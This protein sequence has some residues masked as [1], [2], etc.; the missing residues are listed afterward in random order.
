MAD[1]QT[2]SPAGIDIGATLGGAMPAGLQDNLTSLR[3]EQSAE[4]TKTVDSI[5]KNLDRDTANTQRWYNAQEATGI[6]AAKYPK[7]NAQEEHDKRMTDPVEAFGS[8]G[9]VVGIL[10]SAFVHAPIG[11]AFEASAAAINAIKAGDEKA[12]ERAHQGWKDNLDLTIKRHEIV[13]NEYLDAT[14][15][16]KTN[17]AAGEARL[18]TS[19]I[20][21]GDKR[22]LALTEAGM[23]KEAIE[24]LDS[25]NKAVEGLRR[26]KLEG[27]EDGIKSKAYDGISKGIDDAAKQAQA[28]GGQVDP[29]E[30]AGRKLEAFNRIYHAD[31]ETPQQQLMGAY[32]AQHPLATAEEAAKYA[33]D[34]GI[35]HTY[36]PTADDALRANLER[37]L[38]RPPTTEEFANAKR[39][40]SGANQRNDV[41]AKR[42][43][44][45]ERHNKVLEEIN[46]GKGDV[47]QQRADE[48][49][50]HNKEMEKL[51]IAGGNT[52][53]TPAR[54][55][56]ADVQRARAKWME[57]GLS[58]AEIAEKSAAL[59][60]KLQ[61]ENNAPS[62]N[63]VDDMRR[64]EDQI[65][66]TI[67]HIDKAQALLKKHNAITG[68]GGSVL[69]RGE[70]V[71]SVLGSNST[72]WHEFE[73][74]VAEI[75]TLEP[76]ILTDSQGRPL[77]SES[78]LRDKIV[79]G[80]GAGDTKKIT[81]ERF[82]QLR[83]DLEDALERTRKRSSGGA[84]E[85]SPAPAKK[86]PWD[87]APIV[88]PAGQ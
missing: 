1:T 55:I 66:M 24:Y 9:S 3:R 4:T 12:Y 65:Q 80:L 59:S 44:E 25:Q 75:K 43:A 36:K 39:D 41:T 82:V 61:T 30:V 46:A 38:G 70:T 81:V 68:I 85:S 54:R 27:I 20:K 79:R 52:Q 50:R 35:I 83:R 57:E 7:W 51:K 17:L 86:N 11:A 84:S 74:V 73:S 19:A 28:A 6:E 5:D 40:V 15:M 14:N 10:A 53:L 29:M 64:R 32:F 60:K 87:S 78:E 76:R 69:R 63:R 22:L 26:L 13:R 71:A 16:M 23:D 62:G 18:K 31:K 48:T 47:A 45:I 34:N 77:A 49:E 58:D 37:D 42:N 72:D 2:D 8:L 56:E 21:F 67:G 33:L 88:T